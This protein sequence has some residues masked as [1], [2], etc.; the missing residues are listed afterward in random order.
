MTEFFLKK[1]PGSQPGEYKDFLFEPHVHQYQNGTLSFT[2]VSKDNEGQ[3]LC[4]A[5]NNIGSGVSKVIFLKVN[6]NNSLKRMFYTIHVYIMYSLIFTSLF[7][8]RRFPIDNG[9][10]TAPAHFLQKAK[11]VQV[12]K[13]EQAHLQCSALGD[14]PMEMMWK[15][16]SLHIVPDSDPRFT[17]REQVMYCTQHFFE[18]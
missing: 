3:Y 11:Q 12:V 15:M 13:G 17:I 8:F 4:E 1:N 9:A 7:S 10:R 18:K 16:G 6:G 14:T 5:K 2:H